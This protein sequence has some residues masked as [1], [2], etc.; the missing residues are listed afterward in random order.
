MAAVD[1]TASL[2]RVGYYADSAELGEEL[3][4][5]YIRVFGASHRE[6]LWAAT[7]IMNSRRVNNNLSGARDGEGP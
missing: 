2:R 1:L 3:L 5:R 4:D 7:N 6:T